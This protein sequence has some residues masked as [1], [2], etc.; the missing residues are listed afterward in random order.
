MLEE[1]KKN[2]WHAKP[3]TYHCRSP[4]CCRTQDHSC[5]HSC[6][7]SALGGGLCSPSSASLSD[8]SR[9][10]RTHG[11]LQAKSKISVQSIVERAGCNF[12]FKDFRIYTEDAGAF[13]PKLLCTYGYPRRKKTPPTKNNYF[14]WPEVQLP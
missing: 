12:S 10:H 11:R 14:C 3:G 1:R 5:S 8:P 7:P 13:T 4:A 2:V 6:P 9:Q